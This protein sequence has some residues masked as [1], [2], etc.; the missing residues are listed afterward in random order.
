VPATAGAGLQTHLR[1]LDM[2]VGDKC[3]VEAT[4]RRIL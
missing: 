2:P 1:K 4:Q 3:I